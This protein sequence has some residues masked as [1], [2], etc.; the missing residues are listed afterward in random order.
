[1]LQ[2]RELNLDILLI[3]TGIDSMPANRYPGMDAELGGSKSEDGVAVDLLPPKDVVAAHGVDLLPA[4]Q[5]GDD[6]EEHLLPAGP[7]CGGLI[8]RL[9][10]SR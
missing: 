1:M 8:S 2:Y 9:D 4:Y 6:M 5:H 7:G 3:R 10:M